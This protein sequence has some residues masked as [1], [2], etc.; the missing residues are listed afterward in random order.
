MSLRFYFRNVS[1]HLLMQLCGGWPVH[2]LAIGS[3]PESRAS[4]CGGLGESREKALT[5]KARAMAAAAA[6]VADAKEPSPRPADQPQSQP[7]PQPQSQ[8]PGHSRPPLAPR[9]GL[10]PSVED[11]VAQLQ[12]LRSEHRRLQGS[13]DDACRQLLKVRLARRRGPDEG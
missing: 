2:R 13:W 12:A 6:N 1:C 11:V 9:E 10:G 8:P 5:A 4:G 3:A 7:Q